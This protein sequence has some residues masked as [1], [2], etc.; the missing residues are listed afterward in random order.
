MSDAIAVGSYWL[1]LL[2]AKFS[3]AWNRASLCRIWSTLRGLL[4]CLGVGHCVLLNSVAVTRS[5]GAGEV[6]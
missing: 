3:D 4:R 6:N 5:C 1:L 2:V